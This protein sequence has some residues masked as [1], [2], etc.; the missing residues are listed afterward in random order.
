LRRPAFLDHE[1]EG[2]IF[3]TDDL[4][5]IEQLE[6]AI[7]GNVFDVLIGAAPEKNGQRYEGESDGNEDNPATIETRLVPP[8]FVL[9]LRITIRLRHGTKN[10]LCVQAG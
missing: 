3:V 6:E 8:R 7:V 10:A 2:R 1:G 9:A 4:L 5:V